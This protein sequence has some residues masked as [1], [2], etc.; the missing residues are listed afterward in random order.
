MD[1]PIKTLQR[2]AEISL[3]IK[4]SRFV[5]RSFKR[6][7]AEDALAALKSVRATHRDADHNVWAFRVGP[8]GEQARYSDD[9]EPGGTAG[10][11]ILDVLKRNDV[12]FALVVVTRYFGGT[13]LGAGGLVRA[14]AEGA[15]SVLAA[16]GLKDLRRMAVIEAVVPFGPLASLENYAV[17]EGFD[18]L[19]REFR[20]LVTVT[21]RL[22]GSREAEF[23][24]F[25]ANLVGGKFA[26]RV[27]GEGYF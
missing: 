1:R 22:P 23:R 17:R 3:E 8:T 4:R 6:T 24:A 5:S 14:Y 20:D 18:I 19:S 7:T 16:S 27:V 21:V 2:E 15:K 25:H 11:P 13:K 26:S 10:P 9:G 12:T